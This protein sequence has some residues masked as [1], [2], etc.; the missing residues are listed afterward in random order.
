MGCVHVCTC[1]H[2]DSTDSP[3][4]SL[5]Q[6]SVQRGGRG[7]CNAPVASC[8]E[9]EACLHFQCRPHASTLQISPGLLLVEQCLYLLAGCCSALQHTRA[10]ALLELPL[11]TR[12]SICRW[13]L[14]F[15][16]A[17]MCFV[18]ELGE[19]SRNCFW[20]PRQ[21]CSWQGEVLRKG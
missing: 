20:S 2:P 6:K 14:S 5:A 17:E 1:I 19:S 4:G 3:F 13:I 21:G 10:F 8:R 9:R 15:L 16:V 11:F 7:C 18:Q 12:K